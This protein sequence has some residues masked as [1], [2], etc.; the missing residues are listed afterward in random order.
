M[1]LRHHKPEQ[2]ELNPKRHQEDQMRNAKLVTAA[3]A[4]AGLLSAALSVPADAADSASIS[5]KVAFEGTPP[6]P[7]KIKVDA[8]PKCA[9]MH[10]DEPLYTQEVEVNDNGTL[11]NVFVYVK[12]GLAGK[13]YEPPKEPVVL[14]Q[15]GCHY[16]P[17]VFG[18][19]AKQ[20]LKIRNSDDTLHNIHALPTK[21]KEFNIGQPNK[22]METTRAFPNPEVMVHF[23]CDVHPWMSAYAG[24]LDHPFYSV[25]GQDG[26]FSI[27]GLPAGEYVVEAWHEKYGAQTQTV[28]VGDGEAKEVQYTFKAGE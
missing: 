9:E 10:M 19:M 7:K 11:R 2:A 6:K 24:V 17:H 21:S 5:G 27:K 25:T 4:V 26:S 28:K 3:I 22:G 20:P 16:V 15:V 13:T 14:D 8:D 12:G 18:I 1:C 23:K